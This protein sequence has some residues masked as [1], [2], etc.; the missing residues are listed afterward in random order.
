MKR[1]RA[2]LSAGILSAAAL[3]AASM[4]AVAAIEEV[5]TTVTNLRAESSYGFI[6]TAQ[7]LPTCGGRVWVDMN[8]VL[9]RAAY[10]TAMMAFAMGKTVV[11]RAY[12]E[13]T[14]VF[15]ACNLYDIY[16]TQ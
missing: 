2:R 14:H 7:P 3:G 4:P 11:I 15:G 16:V 13:S 8:S 9:G 10:S 1:T 6:G 12:T 5:S